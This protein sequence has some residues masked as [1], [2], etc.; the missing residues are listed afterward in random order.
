[1]VEVAAADLVD[2]ARA[3]PTLLPSLGKLALFAGLALCGALVCLWLLARRRGRVSLYSLARDDAGAV[4]AADYILVAMPFV[5]FVTVMVQITWLMRET[6][7]LHYATYAA[8]RSAR[9]HL[10]PVIPDLPIGALLQSQGILCTDDRE[11]M[12]E[13]TARFALISA[14]PPWNIPCLGAC[15]VPQ[16]AISAIASNTDTAGQRNAML[17]QARYAYDSQNLRIDLR[18]DLAFAVLSGNNPVEPGFRPPVTVR[19]A[20]RHYIITLVGPLLG[21][22]R[23]DGYYYR[24]TSA[25]VTLL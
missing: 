17:S 22:R 4:L 25:E 5:V 8:A 3:S 20:Y 13:K 12:V 1:M 21:V 11:R 15:Q 14:S 19:V 10:C 9:V 16:T 6:I 2:I 18:K 23:S 24:E 7:I